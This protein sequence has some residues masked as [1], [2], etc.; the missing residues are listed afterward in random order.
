MGVEQRKVLYVLVEGSSDKTAL[1]LLLD[2]V[3]A[4]YRVECDAVRGD[5]TTDRKTTTGNIEKEINRYVQSFCRRKSIVRND[6]AGILHLTDSDG[7]YVPERHVVYDRSRKDG[8][9]Y[10]CVEKVIRTQ[11][12]Q[13]IIKRNDKKKEIIDRLLDVEAIHG[14]PYRLFYVSC[15]LDHVLHDSPNVEDGTQ[16]GVRAQV[17]RN[18]YKDDLDAFK[19]F[20]ARSDWSAQGTFKQTWDYLRGEGRYGS[21]HS[22]DRLT[23]LALTWEDVSWLKEKG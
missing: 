2:E 13:N 1:S 18:R 10:D 19:R 11:K 14:T 6:I 8:A 5:I 16:K 12:P 15:N 4:A 21:E 3:F 7:A 23:N 22:L 9:F 17:F 20:I